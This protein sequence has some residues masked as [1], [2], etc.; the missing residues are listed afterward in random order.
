MICLTPAEAL[1]CGLYMMIAGAV[2]RQAAFHFTNYL[3]I[4][5]RRAQ[6]E[7]EFQRGLEG[8]SP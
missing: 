5:R 8:G 3:A 6:A 2:F 1:I 4:R 7:A